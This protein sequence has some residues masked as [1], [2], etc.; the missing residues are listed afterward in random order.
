[1]ATP[2][3]N[4]LVRLVEDEPDAFTCSCRALEPTHP[5]LPSK[6]QFCYWYEESQRRLDNLTAKAQA[7]LEN[8][9]S[10]K[11]VRRHLRL[12]MTLQ[13]SGYKGSSHPKA[14]ARASS[15]R[16]SLR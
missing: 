4:G 15:E 14:I 13:A 12:A 16:D 11:Q 9:K 1:M 5:Q 2:T 8:L 6:V 3:N 7:I 10:E